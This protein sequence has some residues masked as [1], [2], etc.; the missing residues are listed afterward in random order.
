MKEFSGSHQDIT[1]QGWD[2][3]VG[4]LKNRKARLTPARR[5]IFYAVFERHD[6]F[7]ADE[8]AAQLSAGSDRVSRGTVYRTLTLMVE[9][10][11]VREV[12]DSDNHAHFEHILG[13]EDHHHLV[14]RQCGRF[15]E[16]AG[17]VISGRIEQVCSE[18]NFVQDWHSLVVFGWCEDCRR[19]TGQGK[20][21]T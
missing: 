7:S 4:F 2:K 17:S 5:I 16:F 9:A 19:E 11:M 15:I 13:H 20:A 14:C 8:L 6:H 1:H 21:V 10:G 18:N 3:F 12:R